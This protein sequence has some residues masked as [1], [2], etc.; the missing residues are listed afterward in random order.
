M[1]EKANT[2]SAAPAQSDGPVRIEIEESDSEDEIALPQQ[3]AESLAGMTKQD[4]AKLTQKLKSKANERTLFCQRRQGTS[5]AYANN[6]QAQRDTEGRKI[7][8]KVE[9]IPDASGLDNVLK[10]AE[11][12]AILWKKHKGNVV[13]LRDDIK[14]VTDPDEE[15]E[16]KE[17]MG[18]VRVA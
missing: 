1:G 4:F 3:H 17:A 15:R 5:H 7:V 8:M 12:C 13:P 2:E 11:R 6:D 14:R 18:F 10:D 9:E 16:E